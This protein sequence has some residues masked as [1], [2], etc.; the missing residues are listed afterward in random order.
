LFQ[1]NLS[2]PQ[3]TLFYGTNCIQRRNF[4]KNKADKGESDNDNVVKK[5]KGETSSY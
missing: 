5:E 1:N 4:S 2:Q 3:S